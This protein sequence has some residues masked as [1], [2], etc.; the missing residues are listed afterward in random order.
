[1]PLLRT[2]NNDV[3]RVALT[4]PD[5]WVEVKRKLGKDDERRITQMILRGQMV[6]VGESL[7]TF[8]AGAAVDS[9]VFATME[10]AIQKWSIIDPV[11]KRV[12]QLSSQNLRALSDEDV[13]LISTALES[14]Y[15][16][17]ISDDDRKN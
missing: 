12:A 7:D 11:T 1:M 13:A 9:A 17:E 10:V 8:D 16:P 2:S 15:A 3:E 6:K 4:D 14:L 5:E